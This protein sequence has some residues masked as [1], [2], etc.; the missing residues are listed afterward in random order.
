MARSVRAKFKC[1]SVENFE[2]SK[3]AKLNAVYGTSE[4]N[5]DFTKFTPNGNLSIS[6]TN[7][8][9]A[10]GFFEPGKSY[11]LDFNEAPE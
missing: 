6:I 8:A 4:E 1:S 11:Y 5:N 2:G 7:E 3:T 9:P 10:D